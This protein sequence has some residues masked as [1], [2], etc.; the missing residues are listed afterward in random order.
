MSHAADIGIARYNVSFPDGVRVG[1][2][3]AFASQFP[4]GLPVGIGA[5]LV[6]NGQ[7]GEETYC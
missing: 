5:G 7:K 6:F 3:G 2:S 1:Y 4:N